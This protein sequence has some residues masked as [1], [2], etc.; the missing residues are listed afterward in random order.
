MASEKLEG[1][2]KLPVF[3]VALKPDEYEMPPIDPSWTIK[4]ERDDFHE[5]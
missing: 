4:S 2:P 3:P 5:A 1:V